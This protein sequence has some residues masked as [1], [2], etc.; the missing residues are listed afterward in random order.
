VGANGLYQD[1]GLALL[2][3]GERKEPE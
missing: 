3:L 1:C 2:A